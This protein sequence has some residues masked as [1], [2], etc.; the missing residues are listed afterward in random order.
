MFIPAGQRGDCRTQQSPDRDPAWQRAANDGVQLA[1]MTS[2]HCGPKLHAL[3]L[4]LHAPANPIT[5][6]ISL[7]PSRRL[8]PF[9]GD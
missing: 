2:Q 9:A 5:Q 6:I 4:P 7:D 3:P 1:Q 8:Y